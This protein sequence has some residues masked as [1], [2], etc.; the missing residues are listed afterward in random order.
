[1]RFVHLFL[2]SVNPQAINC[3][4]CY[5]WYSY[6]YFL[7]IL[8]GGVFVLCTH[9]RRYLLCIL[10][11]K[12]GSKGGSSYMHFADS[13]RFFLALSL[14]NGNSKLVHLHGVERLAIICID[15]KIAW[16]ICFYHSR[17]GLLFY[18]LATYYKFKIFGII[19]NKIAFC[20]LGEFADMRGKITKN[21][22]FSI[23]IWT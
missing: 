6:I 8:R 1:M 23:T 15:E 16:D 4:F 22:S 10:G 21:C 7:Q 20:V 3:H 11:S 5:N 13:I 9:L 18:I 2:Y 19:F 14:K 17:L 12:C